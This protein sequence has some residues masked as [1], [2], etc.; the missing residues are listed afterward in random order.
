MVLSNSGWNGYPS[1]VFWW[2]WGLPHSYWDTES[3]RV[4]GGRETAWIRGRSSGSLIG[5]RGQSYVCIHCNTCIRGREC[6]CR[7]YGEV[8][9][10]HETVCTQVC[11]YTMYWHAH[12]S[13]SGIFWLMKIFTKKVLNSL[14]C[15]F[16]HKCACQK[17]FGYMVTC[18]FQLWGFFLVIQLRGLF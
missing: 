18:H 3:C 16:F 8:T 15:F 14:H 2:F 4:C 11:C 1:S 17:I 13:Y 5:V 7:H 6:G 9:W 12:T 10:H